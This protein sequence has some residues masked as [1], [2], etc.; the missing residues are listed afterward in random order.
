MPP[1]DVRP[2]QDVGR[3][4]PGPYGL[5]LGVG[6]YG[7]R[8]AVGRDKP[9]PYS[10]LDDVAAEVLERDDRLVDEPPGGVDLR[11]RERP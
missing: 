9:G 11:E 7:L 4:K 8:G 2:W 3:D 5:R 10:G 1:P 6:P